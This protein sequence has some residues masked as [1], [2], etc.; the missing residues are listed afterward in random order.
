MQVIPAMVSNPFFGKS[1]H[2]IHGLCENICWLDSN[3]RTYF[4]SCSCGEM[5]VFDRVSA[6]F[7]FFRIITP[8]KKSSPHLRPSKSTAFVEGDAAATVVVV[9]FAVGKKGGVGMKRVFMARANSLFSAL[10]L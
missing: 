10:P 9:F 8:K 4:S 3:L 1:I 2:G 7:E 6:L 5:R